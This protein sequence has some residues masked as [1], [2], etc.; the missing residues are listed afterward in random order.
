MSV[1]RAFLERHSGFET[2]GDKH[3]QGFCGD[4]MEMILFVG[5]QEHFDTFETCVLHLCPYGVLMIQIRHN[6]KKVAAYQTNNVYFLT[7][8]GEH[9]M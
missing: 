2:G 8:T 1:T 6:V 9:S 7:T 3:V 5:G 4:F